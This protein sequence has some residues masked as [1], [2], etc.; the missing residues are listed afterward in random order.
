[1][2]GE[3]GPSVAARLRLQSPSLKV[4]FM[5]GYLSDMQ[6]VQLAGASFLQKPFSRVEL[7]AKLAELQRS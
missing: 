2:P 3:D 7:A 1:M 4:L 5:S 6:D